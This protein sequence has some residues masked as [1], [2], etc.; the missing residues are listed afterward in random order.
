[1]TYEYVLYYILPIR[2][3][4]SNLDDYETRVGIFVSC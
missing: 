3:I 4:N 1:M 2:K